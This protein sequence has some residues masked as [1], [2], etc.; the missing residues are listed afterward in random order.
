MR[1]INRTTK[2]I[3]LI[4]VILLV[5][6]L[7]LGLVLTKQSQ[8]ALREMIDNRMLDI[9]N[10]AA[11]M[12]DGD[13]LGAV[14]AEDVDTPEYQNVL[15]TLDY[16]QDNIDLEYIYCLR[17]M[18]NDVFV[19]TIDPAD[20]PGEFGEQVIYTEALHTASLGTPCVDKEAYGDRWGR[21]YSAYSPVFNSKNEVSGIVAVDFSAD[22]YDQQMTNQFRTTLLI[23]IISLIIT[24]T[25]IFMII[26]RFRRRF[27]IML[28]QMNDI[29]DGID[30]LVHEVSPGAE[31]SHEKF[32]DYDNLSD[33]FT[34]LGDRIKTLQ[35]ELGKQISYVRS[36]GF[37]DGL[38]GL[39][40]RA[41]YEE[42]IKLLDD[43]IKERRTHFAIALFDVN[44]LKGINDRLGHEQGDCAIK[45]VAGALSKC[46]E[47]ANLYRIGGDEFVA[48]FNG[49]AHDIE[50]RFR[51]VDKLLAEKNVASVAKGYAEFK[52]GYHLRYREVFNRADSAMYNDKKEFYSRQN[53]Q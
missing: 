13:T 29:S 26:G 47:D 49:P 44:G 2:Y 6:N 36:M 3:V 23:A 4:C 48:L 45:E 5:A 10:T 14:Q 46:F 16:F 7:T 1:K 25:I 42:H 22:W 53:Q 18:G 40:N 27:R 52:Q 51:N 15:K 35:D 43:A 11:A 41:A 30:T 32:E 24:L 17:D 12:I 21:F 37:T 8:A 39:G 19:F 38:T 28:E 50:E 31:I 34:E 9:S 20:D 33:G